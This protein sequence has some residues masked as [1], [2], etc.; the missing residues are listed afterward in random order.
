MNTQNSHASI[1]ELVHVSRFYGTVIGLGDAN[2]D[3][4]PGAYGLVG[5]NGSGKTTFINLIT[6]VLAPS[7]GDVQVFGQN[8]HQD[9]SVL[10]RIGLCPASDILYPNVSALQWVEYLTGLH[11]FTRQEAYERAVKALT[12]VGMEPNMHRPI[13]SYSLGM[14][15]RSKL[16]Q[17]IAHDPE[18]LILDEPFNGLD[19]IAR[20]ELTEFLNNW[21]DQGKSL[22]LA[23]HI[24]HEV[25]A[26]TTSF[27]L[28]H[29]G[30]I[31]ASGD[32]TEVRAML[33]GFPVEVKISG[34]GLSILAEALS[35][36]AWIRG[37]DF[38]DNGNTL[39]VRVKDKGAFQARLLELSRLEG[40]VI[41]SLESPDGSLES[42]F[43][44]L[45]SVHR[46][47]EAIEYQ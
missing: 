37:M 23:S 32:A 18:L 1:L 42:A 13:G 25:E 11:G 17:A 30:R 20:H 36:E 22:I 45:L 41:S 29:G 34:Q 27:L 28:I 19:P 24:L 39:Q 26:I 31:L 7:I 44:L 46:G 4:A 5:P 35:Q 2:L 43:D 16:A 3:L 12:Q 8:P 10:S 15:Q 14:R 21:V 40:V 6:G 47:Q 38:N 33:R 9:R